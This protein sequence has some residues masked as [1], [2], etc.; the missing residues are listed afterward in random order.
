MRRPLDLLRQEMASEACATPPVVWM[1][2]A[3]ASAP[4]RSAYMCCRYSTECNVRHWGS[5]LLGCRDGQPTD[6]GTDRP[7][8]RLT[9][10]Q[11][12]RLAD[13]QTKTR[14]KQKQE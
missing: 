4:S 5:P 8:D 2:S 14:K 3:A 7:T 1:L 9:D 10:G 12:H 13:R 6:G 11:P